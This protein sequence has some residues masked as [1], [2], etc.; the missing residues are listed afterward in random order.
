MRLFIAEKPSVAKAIAEELGVTAKEE[1]YLCCGDDRITWCF[2]HLLE[3][4]EPDCYTPEDAPKS[5][6]TGKKLWR[7]E[8]LPIIP[9]HWIIQPK[10]DSKK[11]LKIIGNL[12]KDATLV[13]NAGDADREGQLLVDEVLIYFNNQKPVKRFWVA[14]H[15]STSL[16]R[17]L[18]SMSDNQTYHGLGRAALARSQ[19]DWLIGMNLSR[20][21]TLNAS[22]NGQRA[23]VTVGRV[24]TPTL[25][26]V[27]TRDREIAAFQSKPF[28]TIKAAFN[29]ENRTFLADWKA[30]ENQQGLDEEDRLIDLNR[31]NRL[32]EQV[33]GRLGIIKAYK[34]ELQTKQHPKA[35]SLSDLTLEASNRH[36]FSASEVLDVCQALYE[37]HKLTTYP[38]TDCGFLPESQFADARAI[39]TTL[40][41]INPEL[42]HLIDKADV[43]IKSKTW[44]DKKVTVHFGIIPT[45]HQ[46][47]KERLSPREGIIYE[48]IVKRYIAQFYP[49]HEYESTSIEIDVESLLFIAKGKTIVQNGW[50]D[51]YEE[52]TEEPEQSET[53]QILPVVSQGSQ[54]N[55]LKASRVD[56][57]TKPPAR[58]TEGTLQRAMENIHK[59][60]ADAD[61]KKLL[62]DGDGIG[63]PATRAS[64]ISEL[65]NRGFIEPKGKNIVSTLLGQSIVD[66]LPETVK[67]PVL[68]AMFERI[69]KTIEQEPEHFGSFMEKQT[70]FVTEQVNVANQQSIT[71]SGLKASEPHSIFECRTCRQ[72]LIQRK[73]PKGYWWGCSSYPNCKQTYPDVKGKPHYTLKKENTNA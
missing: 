36:G 43:S 13:I 31:A 1:G 23:L 70:A 47:S 28:Y 58:F 2:G 53:N 63:T 9:S 54:I 32:V 68:T 10:P 15:D 71:L 39:L 26:L 67:S 21:Y 52:P 25:N 38:R 24:Q 56:T 19:A 44:D 11:Q 48:L 14:A 27:V 69:L 16:K 66:A 7:M 42:T 35:Y 29:A 51:V 72:K 6:K 64:I 17:G 55:C 12:L 65:K 59:Y 33:S 20:A 8:D 22:K 4:A 60:I 30:C 62:R 45:L 57:K 46:G 61:H 50:C 41:V 40:S 3:L 49:L 18:S 37:T 34:K 5:P 73:S